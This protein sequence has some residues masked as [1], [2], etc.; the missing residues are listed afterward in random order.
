MVEKVC[1]MVTIVK[2]GNQF[3]GYVSN[4]TNNQKI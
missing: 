2:G 3:H 4:F 1:A